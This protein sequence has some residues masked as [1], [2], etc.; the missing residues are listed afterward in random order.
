MAWSLGVED[1][2]PPSVRWPMGVE[3]AALIH[4]RWPTVVEDAPTCVRRLM[5]FQEDALTCARWPIEGNKVRPPF[6]GQLLGKEDAP[7]FVW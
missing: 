6:V 7:S 5:G 3:D 1:A 2:P 4:V